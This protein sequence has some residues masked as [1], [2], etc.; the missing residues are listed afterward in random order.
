LSVV[1]S[2]KTFLNFRHGQPATSNGPLSL[3]AGG[4]PAFAEPDLA[5]RIFGNVT[6]DFGAPQ[7]LKGAAASVQGFGFGK[8]GM[9]AAQI[10]PLDSMGMD[11]GRVGHNG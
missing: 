7:R 4:W 3:P 5:G 11:S 6:L 10:A 9:F 2:P 8:L 1:S